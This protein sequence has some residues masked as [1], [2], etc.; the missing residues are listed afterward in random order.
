MFR[1][2]RNSVQACGQRA[3]RQGGHGHAGRRLVEAIAPHQNPGFCHRA[4]GRAA[5]G[6][7]AGAGQRRQCVCH[8][9]HQGGADRRCP[10]LRPANF[11]P[12]S[13]AARVSC[14][15]RL[16]MSSTRRC[17]CRPE[18][19]DTDPENIDRIVSIDKVLL[20]PFPLSRRLRSDGRAV[21]GEIGGPRHALSGIADK[22]GRHRGRCVSRRRQ[23]LYRAA[24]Q[25]RRSA[26]RHRRRQPDRNRLRSQLY[27][28]ADR[29]LSGDARAQGQRQTRRSAPRSQ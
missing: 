11:T 23:A 19:K 6:A 24:A 1:R 27:G 8:R 25:G 15:K 26:V 12:A 13:I 28:A 18:L 3:C 7:A 17:W 4:A 22:S 2:D 21:F 10:P 9:A 5:R 14:T 16:A 29:L 20:G